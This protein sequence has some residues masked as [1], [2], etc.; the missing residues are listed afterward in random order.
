MRNVHWGQVSTGIQGPPSFNLMKPLLQLQ[1]ESP[2]K[3]AGQDG[4]FGSSHIGGQK[5]VHEG[6]SCFGH[7]K[8]Y[9][10]K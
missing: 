1:P 9:K 10:K 8:K 4:R 2:H 3:N 5:S 6:T 7:S